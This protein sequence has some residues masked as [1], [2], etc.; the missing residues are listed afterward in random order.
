LTDKWAL[1]KPRSWDPTG[2][3]PGNTELVQR[4]D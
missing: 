4:R 1:I 2:E 3:K